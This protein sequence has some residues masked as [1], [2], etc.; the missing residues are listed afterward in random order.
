MTFHTCP[1]HDALFAYQ[2]GRLSE[3]SSETIGSHIVSCQICQAELSTFDGA[4]DSFI[5]QLR[6]PTVAAPFLDESECR[7][8][9]GRARAVLDQ[10]RG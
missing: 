4:E 3:A 1:S 10:S 8:A 6:C 2:A 9:V 5:G 7:A